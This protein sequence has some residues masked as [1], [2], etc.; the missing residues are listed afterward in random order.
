MTE[1]RSLFQ[2]LEGFKVFG[3][4]RVKTLSVI[5]DDQEI[6]LFNEARCFNTVLTSNN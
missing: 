1:L 2:F 4:Y 3:V 6:I 5:P